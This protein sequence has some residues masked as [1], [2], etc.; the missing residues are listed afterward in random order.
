MVSYKEAKARKPI[1]FLNIGPEKSAQVTILAELQDFSYKVEHSAPGAWYKTALC[2]Y[3]E[4]YACEHGERDWNQRIKV[5]IPVLHRGTFKVFGA[6]MGTNS[7]LHSLQDYYKD[8]GTIRD[9]EFIISRNG[10]GK[11]SKYLAF[12]VDNS[13]PAEYN[14]DIRLDKIL[15]S[16]EYSKQ[17][18]YYQ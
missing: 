18:E 8:H 16:V 14:G 6:G 7:V 10:S 5:Y 3:P 13:I 15:H 11:R 4:C 1:P 12:P 9:T 2:T 17:A